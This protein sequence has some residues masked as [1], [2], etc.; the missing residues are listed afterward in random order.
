[1]GLVRSR[2][3]CIFGILLFS[4]TASGCGGTAPTNPSAEVPAEV[5]ISVTATGFKPSDAVVAVGGRAT[6]TNTDDRLHSIASLPI[7]THADCPPINEVGT[8]VPGQSR[9]TGVF[10]DAKTCGYHDTFSE[11]GQL[12]TGNITVR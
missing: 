4:T 1:M 6:F 3:A 12:L 11:G 7:T 9:Q 5:T 2:R 8:L 10:T